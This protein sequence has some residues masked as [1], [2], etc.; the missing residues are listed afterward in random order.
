M[1]NYNNGKIYKIECLN[2]GCND[3]YIGS[4]TK[5]Y[6][7]KRMVNHRSSYK[8]YKVDKTA[9]SY[10]S[11]DIFDKYGVD[12][13]IITL[14]ELVN[15]NSKD[16]LLARESYFI[17][18]L[19]C[20]NKVIPDRTIKEY[21]KEYEKLQKVKEYRKQYHIDNAD[22]IKLQAK[23]YREDNKLKMSERRKQ[24]YQNKKQKN[25]I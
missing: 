17:R 25:K 10:S 5:D 16:E 4:T 7:S 20:V 15:C 1:V 2:E 8:R 6:L 12:N 24:Y 19:V 22:K 14:L 18:T 3:I 13:C 21:Q 23:L 11:F 9:N